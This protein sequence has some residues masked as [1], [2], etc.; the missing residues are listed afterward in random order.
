M[1]AWGGSPAHSDDTAV[2]CCMHGRPPSPPPGARGCGLGRPRCCAQ[3]G[4]DVF[5]REG[6]PGLYRGGLPLLL[7]GAFLWFPS[8]DAAFL[9][10]R[11]PVILAENDSNDGKVS[12]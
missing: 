8:H 10:T 4:K 11:E 1:F 3:V 7:G 12:S 2:L 9:A 6:I 5:A